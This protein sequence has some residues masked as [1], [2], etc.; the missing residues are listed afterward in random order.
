M[1]HE[2]ANKLIN[3]TILENIALT[4][5]VYRMRL[6]GDTS[7]IQKPGQFIHIQIEGCYLRRPISVSTWSEE[8]LVIVYKVVGKGTKILSGKQPNDGLNALVGLGNGF[9]PILAPKQCVVI[10]G[11][12]GIPPLLGLCRELIA[13]HREVSVVLGFN[14]K[15]DVFYQQ[16]FEQLGCTTYVCTVDGSE[17]LQGMV[18]DALMAKSL[19]HQYYFTCGPLAMMKAIAKMSTNQGQLSFEEKMGCGYGACLSCSCKTKHGYARICKEGPVL[20]SEEVIWEN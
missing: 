15:T 18:S 1:H 3:Y 6:Q 9:S 8:A 17:G 13:N 20:M 5:T 11:G 19:T 14:T 10:G 16:E 7:W 12:V 4:P 2:K